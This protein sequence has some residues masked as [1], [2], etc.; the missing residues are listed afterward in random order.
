M[1]QENYKNVFTYAA[2][3]DAYFE[4]AMREIGKEKKTTFFS[5]LG[6]A[7]WYGEKAVKETYRDVLGSWL[8]SYEFFTEFVISLNWKSFYWYGR[9]DALCRLYS[10]LYQKAQDEFYKHYEGNKKALR[11]Y[12][13]MTN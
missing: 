7:E 3:C 13:E 10:E 6:I 2:G 11:Y 12:Y 1:W 8:D 5:D 9:N 4:D